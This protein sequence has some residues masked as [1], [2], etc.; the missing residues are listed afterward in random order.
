MRIGID[1][2]RKVLGRTLLEAREEILVEH[3]GKV[4]GRFTPEFMVN[5][6]VQGSKEP[7][8]VRFA[9]NNSTVREEV[10]VDQEFVQCQKCFK[11]YPREEI[12][13][14]W[15]GETGEERRGCIY[16]KG[17]RR[18]VEKSR[19]DLSGVKMNGKMREILGAQVV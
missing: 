13:V 18:R 6:T 19:V 8:T 7:P 11:H 3:R 1:A 17:L 16:C 2:L 15:V 5:S 4:V 10:V 14:E 12:V 9:G